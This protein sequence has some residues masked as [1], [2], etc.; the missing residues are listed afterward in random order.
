MTFMAESKH[1]ITLN[2]KRIEFSVT[3]ELLGGLEPPTSGCS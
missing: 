3:L 1:K 2:S